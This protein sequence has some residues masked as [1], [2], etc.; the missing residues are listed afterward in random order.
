MVI[1]KKYLQNFARR[2]RYHNGIDWEKTLP[3][4]LS[5]VNY[6]NDAMSQAFLFI[7]I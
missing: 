2:Y 5:S 7:F 1:D 3:K 4:S 6:N